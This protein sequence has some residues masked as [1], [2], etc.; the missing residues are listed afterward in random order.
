MDN[1]FNHLILFSAVVL[2]CTSSCN[3]QSRTPAANKQ[4]ASGVSAKNSSANSNAG[5]DY[6]VFTRARISDQTAFSSPVEAFSYLIPKGWKHSGEVIWTMPGNA[7]AGTNSFFK[8]SSPDGKYSFEVY[9]TYTW[10]FTTDQQ[11]AQFSQQQATRYCGFGEPLDAGNYVR[12]AFLPNEAGNP[13]VIEIKTN[14]PG[15]ESIRQKA[16]KYRRELMSYGASQVNFYPSAVSAKVKWNDGTEGIALCGVIIMET[17]IPNPYNGTYSKSYTTSTS[18]KVLFRYPASEKA[19]AEKL[20][21]V[22]MSSARSNQAWANAV[23]NYWLQVR[24]QKQAAHL[25]KIRMMDEYTRQMGENAIRKGQQNLER[26]DANM[27]N[28]EA[29]QQSQDRMHTNFVKAIRE[30]ENY[31]DENG[32]VE[33]SSGYNHAWSRSDGSSFI[34]TDNPNFDPSSVF[35]DQQWKE[36]KKVE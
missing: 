36:M 31:R 28:W 33:L 5:T 32:K 17:T 15:A 29:Q 18:E 34:M 22:I 16:E 20:L 24:Q 4:H 12:Q 23:N 9:P 30:V 19:H 13:S 2:V 14:E 27:R 10:S 11:V 3:S 8:A 6:T 7:C 26:M 1:I 21:S 35:R 25:D